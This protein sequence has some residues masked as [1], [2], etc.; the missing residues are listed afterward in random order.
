MVVVL[1]AASVAAAVKVRWN[2]SVGISLRKTQH[3]WKLLTTILHQQRDEFIEGFVGIPWIE[4]G[5]VPLIAKPK[6]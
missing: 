6:G 2:W 5:A 1:K 3:P 4:G